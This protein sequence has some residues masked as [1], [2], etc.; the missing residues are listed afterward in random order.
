MITKIRFFVKVTKRD[1]LRQD[2]FIIEDS[3]RISDK[4]LAR[5]GN[6]KKF[7]KKHLRKLGIDPRKCV[8]VQVLKTDPDNGSRAYPVL[9]LA[10]ARIGPFAF[11]RKAPEMVYRF[12]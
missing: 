8:H 12:R 11:F 4:N 3:V 1:E 7:K 9:E 10:S 2:G 6:P 5:L